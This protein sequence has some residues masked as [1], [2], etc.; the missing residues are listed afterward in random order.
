MGTVFIPSLYQIS[1]A[2]QP[3]SP[4]PPHSTLSL[5]DLPS[6]IKTLSISLKLC[7]IFYKPL[8]ILPRY[9]LS[10]L[11][12]RRLN[13]PCALPL[14]P[15]PFVHLIYKLQPIVCLMIFSTFLFFASCASHATFP[16]ISPVHVLKP[17][18]HL[19]IASLIVIGPSSEIV[20]N[21]IWDTLF[22]VLSRVAPYAGFAT[23]S[24]KLAL[25]PPSLLPAYPD[26]H[27]ADV[28]LQLPPGTT[29]TSS[30]MLLI[31]LTC[32]PMPSLLLDNPQTPFS[33]VEH[34]KAY[35]NHKFAV[36]YTQ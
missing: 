16:P 10:P 26:L 30:S 5:S 20:H 21:H 18:M 15:L 2:Y 28:A 6:L 24:S 33:V 32:I 35:E 9:L 36:Q 14:L 19:A 25:E 34:H 27:P 1:H 11:T 13:L 7:N 29:S 12:F 31:G 23:T 3:F 17:V 4:V 8:H 22:F